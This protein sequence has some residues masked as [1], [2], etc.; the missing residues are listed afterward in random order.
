MEV[1]QF[2]VGFYIIIV[3]MGGADKPIEAATIHL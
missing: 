3:V 2:P 1:V